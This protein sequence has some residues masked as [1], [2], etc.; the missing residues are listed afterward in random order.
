MLIDNYI[1][2]S[3]N[4]G[5]SKYSYDLKLISEIKLDKLDLNSYFNI[6]LLNENM[7]IIESSRSIYLI[8]KDE[9]KYK[10]EYDSISYFRQVLIINSNYFLVLKVELS[11]Y[12]INYCLYNYESNVP[13]K[14]VKSN[15]SYIQYSC[16]ISILSDK[17]Y[18]VCFL[19][20]DDGIYYKILDSQLN[21]IVSDIKISNYENNQK[22]NYI[23]SISISETKI[24]ILLNSIDDSYDRLNEVIYNKLYLEIFEFSK[25]Y[26]NFT[27]NKIN[28]EDIII[29]DQIYYGIN[30]FHMKKINEEE[31]VVVFPIDTTRKNFNFT[32]LEYKNGILSIKEKYKNIPI[33]LKN[34]I[35]GLKFLKIKSDFA[36]SFYYF[37]NEEEE[38]IQE[39]FLSYLT[40]K[41]C[42]DFEI[43]NITNTNEKINFSRYIS[44]DLIPSEPDEQKIKIDNSNA[45]SISFF[46]DN[47]LINL[48]NFYDFEKLSYNTG[49]KSGKFHVSYSILSANDY[50]ERTCKITF[51]ILEDESSSSSSSSIG[52]ILAIIF[53]FCA[54]FIVIVIFYIRKKKALNSS[55]IFE[56][57][58]SMPLMNEELTLK[59]I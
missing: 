57:Q 41:N 10:I 38:E 54:V 48:D 22:I 21:E 53:I 27:I 52:I 13:V 1:L 23:Y 42:K 20:D 9:I 16:N 25:Q 55:N 40:T 35:Q 33:S 19:L 30:S 50:M 46:Y 3:Y 12:K 31:L 17:K 6:H 47:K 5:L 4:G 24:I 34:E 15:Q 28:Q 29:Y 36:I 51:N 26:G 59:L 11:S 8:E 32:I 45:S 43:I 44:F 2:V 7:I 56:T 39:V 18:I 37:N 58:N 14:T 49:K